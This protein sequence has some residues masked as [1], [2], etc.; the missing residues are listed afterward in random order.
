V[1]IHIKC[2][3]KAFIDHLPNNVITMLIK[4]EKLDY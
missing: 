3:I 1:S 2:P 4:R